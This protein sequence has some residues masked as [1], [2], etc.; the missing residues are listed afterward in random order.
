MEDKSNLILTLVP[1]NAESVEICRKKE[2]YRRSHEIMGTP[3]LA[4][5]FSCPP[6]DAKI[7]FVFGYDDVNCDVKFPKFNT[8]RVHFIITF[9]STSGLLLLANASKSGTM[10]G[11]KVLTR[12][13]QSRILEHQ[14]VINFGIYGFIVNIPNR[15]NAQKQYLR[16]Q[17]AYLGNMVSLTPALILNKYSTPRR[18]MNRIGPFSEVCRVGEGGF[19]E[20]L[21]LCKRDT[22]DMYAA[23]RYLD[24]P[25][26]M[27][28][29]QE[30]GILCR[31][32]HVCNGLPLSTV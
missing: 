14:E 4:L 7:G 22:G 9:N 20:V 12:F 31:L 8:G 11:T 6:K 2:N 25:P 26:G 19:G 10:V 29:R 15:R 30:A 13:N 1:G 23:K 28:M 3:V 16:N 24:A 27:D 5:T 21:L 32:S 17:G 18:P